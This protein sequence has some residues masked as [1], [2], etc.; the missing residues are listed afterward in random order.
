MCVLSGVRAREPVHACVLVRVCVRAYKR[1]CACMR[2]CAV[3]VRSAEK[4]D[5]DVQRLKRVARACVGGV[6]G[7][8]VRLARAHACSL[9]WT[10]GP[11]VPHARAHARRSCSRSH[12]DDAARRAARAPR[13]TAREQL[14]LKPP[15][16]LALRPVGAREEALVRVVVRACAPCRRAQID[17]EIFQR[18][19]CA[20][21]ARTRFLPRGQ[22]RRRR[23][24]ARRRRPDN[25]AFECERTLERRAEV[26]GQ[27]PNARV[28]RA[29][30]VARAR[31][32]RVA[33][34][35]KRAVDACEA[36]A[37]VPHAV[38]H[39]R[40]D[41]GMQRRERPRLCM[42]SSTLVS[43]PPRQLT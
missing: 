26:F 39:A 10:N 23:I 12:R 5:G 29:R 42:T 35:G 17:G 3:C 16:D 32:E 43:S 19:P 7:V 25:Q 24:R 20:A 6:R 34:G 1:A 40:R 38:E 31:P 37:L 15:H 33:R 41:E 2:A 28:Q 14:E 22:R 8:Y 27:V 9:N 4:N 13:V 30:I 21:H 11:R 18:A 36:K